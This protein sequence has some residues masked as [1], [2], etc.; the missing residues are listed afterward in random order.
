MSQ[1]TLRLIMADDHAVARRG[2]RVLLEEQPDLRVVGEAGDGAAALDLARAERPD[3]AVLDVR[4]PTLDGVR[5]CK[6]IK[7]EVPETQVLI[8]SAYEDDRYVFGLLAAG[9]TGYILKDAPDDEIVA[10]VR[11][12]G[13]HEPYLT[14]RIQTRAATHAAGAQWPAGPQCSVGTAAAPHKGPLG[15]LTPRELEV[16]TLMAAGLDNVEIAER[17]FVSKVTVQNYTSSIYS[18][19]DVNT[20][21][22]AILYAMQHGLVE[23]AREV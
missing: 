13:R 9:A 20:R 8:L 7:Q 17:L 11:A 5:A 19:L 21:A 15:D 12:A 14:P 6:A 16:L 22:K 10:A 4:M 2:L 1:T 18:K 23:P 3:V